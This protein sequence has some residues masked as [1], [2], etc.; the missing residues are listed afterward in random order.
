MDGMGNVCES[1]LKIV[2]CNKPKAL[3]G[4]SQ[5]GMEE[6]QGIGI[7]PAQ[8]TFFPVERRVLPHPVLLAELGKPVMF[9]T[10]LE[11]ADCKEGR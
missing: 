7:T 8:P 2:R 6:G 11:K 1:S 5:K 10:S 9:S 3:I 4:L